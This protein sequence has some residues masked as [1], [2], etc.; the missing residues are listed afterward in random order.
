M[1]KNNK[2]LCVLLSFII[3]LSSLPIISYAGT[4]NIPKTFSV[5]LGGTLTIPTDLS[6]C[7]GKQKKWK[8]NGEGD[9]ATITNSGAVTGRSIGTVSAYCTT[10]AGELAICKIDVVPNAIVNIDKSNLTLNIGDSAKINSSVSPGDAI[11]DVTWMSQNSS[12]VSVS[13]D[14]TILALSSGSSIISCV[15]QDG[16]GYQTNCNVVVNPNSTASS[17]S[18]SS[19]SSSKKNTTR[20]YSK[21]RKNTWCQF[22]RKTKTCN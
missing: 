15:S 3:T 18:S 9:V 14:G 8:I 7:S 10:S 21:I 13:N 17:S 19:S 16:T 20:V 22:I 12:V 4:P 1:I 6:N 5:G 2:I 11:Q